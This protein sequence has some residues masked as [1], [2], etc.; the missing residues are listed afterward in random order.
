MASIHGDVPSQTAS[1]NR[2][3]SVRL[4]SEHD[5]KRLAVRMVPQRGRWYAFSLYTWIVAQRRS[6]VNS[7]GLPVGGV[8][9]TAKQVGYCH[10]NLHH[11]AALRRSTPIKLPVVVAIANEKDRGMYWGHA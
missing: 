2:V 6:G 4:R 5:C 7:R 8:T 1:Q 10:R 3:T 9:V 11:G